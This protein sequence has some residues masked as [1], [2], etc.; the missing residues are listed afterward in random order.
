MILL[1]SFSEAFIG[2]LIK[3]QVTTILKLYNFCAFQYD[4]NLLQ[5]IYINTI[6]S[7]TLDIIDLITLH[8]NCLYVNSL[9]L[10]IIE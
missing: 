1:K 9:S 3:K 5:N 8:L 6:L 4:H 10:K 7:N 2:I